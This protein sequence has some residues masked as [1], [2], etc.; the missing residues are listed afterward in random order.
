M[1]DPTADPAWNRLLAAA[2]RSLERSGGSLDATVSLTGPDDAERHLIIGI[3]GI[4]RAST[5]SRLTV[6]LS[7]MDA[8]LR[9]ACDSD[10]TA[11]LG[12]SLRDR[13]AER[14][15]E[16]A[17]R[18]DLLRQAERCV[19]AGSD[20]Y[21]GWL[22][23]VQRDGILT[24]LLRAGRSLAP[25]VTV[26]DALPAADEPMP[27]FAERLL[28]DTKALAD[29]TLRTLLVRAIT[30][31]R[32]IDAPANA[33]AERLLWE[34][35]GVIPDDLAS[36]VL[37]LNLPATGGL[38]GGWLTQAADA[39]IPIRLTLHQL[40]LHPLSPDVERIFITENPAVLRAACALGPS[41]P[42]VICTEGVASAAA[43]RL[44]GYHTTATLWWRNDFDWAGVRMTAAALARYPNARPWR[45]TADDY[46]TA[47]STS[48]GQPLLGTPAATPWEPDLATAMSAT[49]RSVM[50]ERI[51][52]TL[53]ADLKSPSRLAAI[54]ANR[55]PEHGRHPEWPRPAQGA[56]QHLA[57]GT[58]GAQAGGT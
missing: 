27:V 49:G 24:R 33:E 45:M 47:A 11:V 40:R 17:A 25:V 5:V 29:P 7:E 14:R 31:W 46:R 20:W 55:P 30:R 41:A 51:L 12:G 32:D 10:L 22:A 2:R 39:G 44:L 21:A 38:I 18:E 8:Y 23:D 3:T 26:L 52:A 58:N 53:V 4:H 43:H 54:D 6:R 15:A 57:N 42:A 56:P 50:E 19:H 34:S 36:Q 28:N 35:V 13:P 48:I 9:G 37:V 16:N 1:I